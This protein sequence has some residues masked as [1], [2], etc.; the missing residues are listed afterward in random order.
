[1]RQFERR[2]GFR[3]SREE[4]QRA[5]RTAG[6]ELFKVRE[7]NGVSW[8]FLVC[9][10]TWTHAGLAAAARGAKRFGQLL[11]VAKFFNLYD[12]VGDGTTRTL[13]PD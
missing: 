7:R 9:V 3:V 1:M 6:Y 10:D 13:S 8:Y 2:S 11:H 12:G 4:I 5:A